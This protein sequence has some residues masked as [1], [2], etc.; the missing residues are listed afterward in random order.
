M[1][2]FIKSATV[3]I[4]AAWMAAMFPGSAVSQAE[5]AKEKDEKL[6]VM[7]ENAPLEVEIWGGIRDLYKIAVP[8]PIGEGG[9]SAE[10][11]GIESQDFKLSSL[12]EVIDPKSY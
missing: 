9:L 1:T 12:F 10:V 7:S 5:P 11:Q 4:L 8:M 3:F 6:P 2:N